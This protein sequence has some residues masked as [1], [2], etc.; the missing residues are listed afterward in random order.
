M[1]EREGRNRTQRI[2]QLIIEL[3]LSGPDTGA[4]DA[5]YQGRWPIHAGSES[6]TCDSERV[7]LTERIRHVIQTSLVWDVKDEW[8]LRY[9][10]TYSF[11][12]KE[13]HNLRRM[14]LETSQQIMCKTPRLEHPRDRS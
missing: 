4:H 6:K 5:T 7:R 13:I 9:G 8:S 14:A 10:L 2:S 12:S 11:S 1:K 3:L